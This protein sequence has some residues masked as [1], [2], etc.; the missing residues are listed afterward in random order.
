[1]QNEGKPIEKIF[2]K[3]ANPRSSQ[4]LPFYIIDALAK[5][6]ANNEAPI[7]VKKLQ[8]L[9]IDDK[10]GYHDLRQIYFVLNNMYIYFNTLR[11][12]AINCKTGDTVAKAFYL[13]TNTNNLYEP[14]KLV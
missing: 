14:Q 13:K 12:E 6:Q 3:K 10:K 2:K 4:L 5:N 7:T 11:I 9:L 8:R 1:M